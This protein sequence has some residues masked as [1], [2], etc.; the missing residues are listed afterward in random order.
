MKTIYRLTVRENEIGG[1]DWREEK[2]VLEFE[3]RRSAWEA[4]I[5]FDKGKVKG[6]YIK[7]IFESIEVGDE[8]NN[9][10]A[11][12]GDGGQTE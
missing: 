4:M 8:E 6:R 7:F 5:S 3:D 11:G 12:D 1:G 10:V 9:N 2:I